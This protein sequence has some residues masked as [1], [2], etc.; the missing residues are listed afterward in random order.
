M[1]D[2]PFITNYR[3]NIHSLLKSDDSFWNTL[4]NCG[5]PVSV[6]QLP[7]KPKFPG[8]VAGIINA[9]TARQTQ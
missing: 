9:Q 6:K 5:D 8:A 1:V 7:K 2:V 3:N 4:Y